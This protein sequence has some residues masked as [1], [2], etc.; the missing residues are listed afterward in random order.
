MIAAVGD[1]S[2]ALERDG[3]V[4]DWGANGNGQLGS[5]PVPTTNPQA[6]PTRIRHLPPMVAI[7]T[8]GD[9]SGGI[10]RDGTVWTWGDLDVTARG[11][12]ADLLAISGPR[13][14]KGLGPAVALAAGGYYLLAL[15]KDGTVWATGNNG[16]A[17]LGIG[18]QDSTA[19]NHPPVRVHALHGIVAIAAGGLASLALRRDG[20]VWTWGNTLIQNC[21]TSTPIQ[22]PRVRQVAA[23]AANALD[24]GVL[25]RTGTMWL[26]GNN[27]EGELGQGTS[28][29]TIGDLPIPVQ[30]LA[31]VVAIAVGGQASYALVASSSH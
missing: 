17:E 20:T 4:W 14:V 9:V 12:N 26:W 19:D 5:H 10:S 13:L 6:T 29:N 15:H 1:D 8:G 24:Q 22:V 11:P 2:L 23:V 16:D 27:A 21:C 7:A 25:T 30:R 28:E 18:T 31:H 3:S